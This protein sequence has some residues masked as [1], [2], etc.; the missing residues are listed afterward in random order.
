MRSG[1]KSSQ[2]KLGLMS[3]SPL[4]RTIVVVSVH[5]V[6]REVFAKAYPLSAA[7]LHASQKGDGGMWG[8]EFRRML[9]LL[10]DPIAADDVALAGCTPFR[11]SVSHCNVSASHVEEVCVA[12]LCFE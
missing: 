9:K 5:G 2:H 3:T 4:A 12:C 1:R 11:H 10:D 7:V 6:G 8:C